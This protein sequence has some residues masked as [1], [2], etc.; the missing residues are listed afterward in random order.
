MQ[1]F[2]VLCIAFAF[3][4]AVVGVLIA[5]ATHPARTDDEK[6]KRLHA[7]VVELETATREASA[8]LKRV[9]K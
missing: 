8:F 9:A 5:K 1:L 4:G 7:R 6:I 2:H 3:G